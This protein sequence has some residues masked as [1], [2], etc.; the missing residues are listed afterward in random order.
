MNG[1]PAAAR[2]TPDSV[3]NTAVRRAWERVYAGSAT[4]RRRALTW[5]RSGVRPK[6]SG[7]SRKQETA[8][9]RHRLE[10]DQPQEQ[11]CPSPPDAPDQLRCP[12]RFRLDAHDGRAVVR[13]RTRR[14]WRLNAH[15]RIG[16]PTRLGRPQCAN[17]GSE[18]HRGK[19]GPLPTL[20]A[21]DP[22]AVHSTMVRPQK[23]PTRGSA[24]G[25]EKAAIAPTPPP[26]PKPR[27]C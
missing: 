17:G 23:A 18:R 19:C 1:P 15:A 13:D 11:V 10:D 9:H 26:Q 16:T 25:A 5:P 2:L 6:R 22:R 20:S 3:Q 27:S 8:D 12:R 7:R 4:G 21:R 14:E 24:E